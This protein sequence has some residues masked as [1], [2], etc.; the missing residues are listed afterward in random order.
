MRFGVPRLLSCVAAGLAVCLGAADTAHAQQPQL[1]ERCTISVLNRNVR[2]NADGS[3]VLPNVPANFGMVRARAT[4]LID[5]QTISGESEP[6]Q[7]PPNGIVNLPDIIF[8]S[9]TPIPTSVTIAAP[10]RV[11]TEIG[12]TLQLVVSAQYA[13]Q[14]GQD[15]TAAATGTQYTTSNAAIATIS[16]NGAVQ[17][18]A[19]GTVL[20]QAIHEGRSGLISIQVAPSTTDTDGDGIPDDFELSLG[21][22]PNDPVDAL[23][24]LDRDGLTNLQEFQQGT[25]IRKADTDDDGLTDSREVELGTSPVVPDTDGDGVR[26]GLEVQT[27]SN[28]TDPTS[29]NLAAALNGITVAPAQFVMTFNTILGDVT[30]QLRV[31][32]TLKD[33]TTIDLTS[34]NRGTN[35]T[36]SDL[37]I[38]NFGATDGLIFAGDQGACT[39]TVTVAGLTRTAAGEVHRFSPTALSSIDVG[40]SGNSVDVSG[41][42]AYVAAG[43]AG[44][45]IIDVGDPRAPHLASTLALAG[46]LNDVKLAGTRAYLAAGSAGLH[47][48]D[49]SNPV[50][51]RLLGTFDTPGD[52]QDV[53]VNGNLAYV[54][55]GGSGLQIIDVSS[56]EAMRRAGSLGNI[57]IAQGVDVTGTLAVVANG[58][59]LRIVNVAQPSQPIA[60]GSIALPGNAYDVVVRGTVAYVAD[61]T[62]SLQVVDVSAPAAPAV[63]GTTPTL[64]GGMLY[65]VAVSGDFSFGADV[66]FVNGVPI[67]D[68]STPANPR[69]RAILQF[70]GDDTG[71]GIAAD[72]SYV[73]LSTAGGRLYIGQYRLLEDL[74]G[75]PPVV[76]IAS[77]APGASFV[78]GETIPIAVMATDDVSVTSVQLLVNGVPGATDTTAPYQFTLTA[79]PAP[80]T[81]VLSASAVDLGDNIG[82]AADLQVHVTADPLTTVA[83]RV[84]GATGQPLQGADV[85]CLA[86]SGLSGAGGSFSVAGV[87]TIQPVI[88][89]TASYTNAQG[90]ELHGTSARVTPVRG[91]TTQVGDIQ[92]LAVPVIG[93]DQAGH[94]Q[95]VPA[96]DHSSR[97]GR[98]PHGRDVQ[99]R[100]RRYAAGDHRDTAGR[101]ERHVGDAADQRGVRIVGN[102]RACG[103]Q[104]GWRVGYGPDAR[105]HADRRQHSTDR[106]CRQRWSDQRVRDRDRHQHVERRLRSGHAAGS[107]GAPLRAGP[108][109]GRRCRAGCRRRWVDEPAGVHGRNQPAQQ[110]HRAAGGR[111]RVPAERRDRLPDQRRVPREICRA[112]AGGAA[113]GRGESRD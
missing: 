30:R 88:F 48:V 94:H 98:E 107:V 63:I 2:A 4:C 39:I 95:F 52:A 104:R 76:S 103:H 31:T 109:R 14:T 83:G 93:A 105:Q 79:P 20:I 89:C 53:R 5:G 101:R 110:P 19:P 61:Y 8:G 112:P 46:V 100:E 49:V 6:F 15:V 65:D 33:N 106:R 66:F 62:G 45:K 50:S 9:L 27:G 111:Q 60:I 57:G 77:P 102:A 67:V 108:A 99:V 44:L 96:A 43:S 17:A 1:D 54:A 41:D 90:T 24:D 81:L 91:G 85:T 34:T 72:G 29:V 51:P 56:P 35:Y 40:G 78:E 73:Y 36:S 12:G 80:A 55:D 10:S 86:Q 23:E 84:L 18:V 13:D 16:A 75:I 64:T 28:P 69:P 59:G 22:N 21:L 74:E 70:P 26:D 32:G 37:N 97:D 58:T 71:Y 47:V 82:V 87:T 42:H 25:N 113:A 68:V 3:W 7:V 38:C 92:L 11:L